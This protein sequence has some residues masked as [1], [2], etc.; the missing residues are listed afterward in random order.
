MLLAAM[1]LAGRA[2]PDDGEATASRGSTAS[3]PDDDAVST[4]RQDAPTTA[5]MSVTPTVQP[6]PPVL[7]SSPATAATRPPVEPIGA[8][9]S[10]VTDP[11]TTS[12]SAPPSAGYDFVAPLPAGCCERSHPFPPS[13]QY[14]EGFCEDAR[15]VAGWAQPQQLYV[16]VSYS[17]RMPE[18]ARA[19]TSCWIC[20][21]P[22]KMS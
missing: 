22:S 20:S 10:V 15:A 21:V 5:G 11:A 6:D 2:S 17:I 9:T 3:I 14:H 12:T 18:I 1:L 19:I 7:E 8:P 16:V 13:P 4:T